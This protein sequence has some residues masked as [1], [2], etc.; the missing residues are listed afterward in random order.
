MACVAVPLVSCTLLLYWLTT[1][2]KTEAKLLAWL[3]A[4]VTSRLRY[5]RTA[6]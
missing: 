2:F 5:M 1:L 6:D 3:D 4:E